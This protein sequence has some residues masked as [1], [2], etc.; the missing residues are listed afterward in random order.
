MPRKNDSM[1]GAATG[2]SRQSS[3]QTTTMKMNFAFWET[4]GISNSM[5]MPRY[6]L[7]TRALMM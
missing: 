5:S 2:K 7:G 6:F 4:W 1:S 3:R